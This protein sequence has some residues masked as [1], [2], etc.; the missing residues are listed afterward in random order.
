MPTIHDFTTA[1]SGGAATSLTINKPANVVAG[2]L[3]VAQVST[4]TAQALT[5]PSGW[6]LASNTVGGGSLNGSTTTTVVQ[7]NIYLK[8]ATASEG[9]SYQWTGT[10]AEFA[11]GILAINKHSLVTA[12]VDVSSQNIDNTSE[13][14]IPTTAATT[15]REGDLIIM[16]ITC[17][18]LVTVTDNAS[19]ANV[20]S[21]QSTTNVTCDTSQK[22][23]TTVGTT[24][25]P[26]ATGGTASRHVADLVAIPGSFDDGTTVFGG[27]VDKNVSSVILSAPNQGQGLTSV[28]QANPATKYDSNEM[29][30]LTAYVHNESPS[31]ITTTTSSS[32]TSVVYKNTGYYVTGAVY[33]S[34]TTVGA[35]ANTSVNPNTGHTLTN[36]SHEA[37]T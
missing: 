6:A 31:P 15:T 5:P 34:W 18:G 7:Q 37:M 14:N 29:P 9:A 13:T 12:T 11:G 35:P 2:D 20:Y 4:S 25:T 32:T 27:P 22:T 24:G 21:Q 1:T 30:W 8:M 19:F 3:L 10:S 16:F 28:S 33:E 17:T 36:L 23:Q 26:A